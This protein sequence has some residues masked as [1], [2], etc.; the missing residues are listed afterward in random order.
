MSARTKLVRWGNS[1]AVRL[2]KQVVERARLAE[3][4]ALTVDATAEGRVTIRKSE[5][6][7]TLED[8]VARITP[9]NRYGETNWGRSVGH[10]VIDEW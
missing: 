9:E 4:E 10:E 2:P 3:G 1:L 8:M 6:E 7:L 5:P